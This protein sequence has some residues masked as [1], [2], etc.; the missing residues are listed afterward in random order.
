MR[1]L[2]LTVSWR[3]AD[4]ASAQRLQARLAP[5]VEVRLESSDH[6]GADGGDRIV[7]A[8]VPLTEPS[9]SA[10]ASRLSWACDLAQENGL[11]LI[12]TGVG[13]RAA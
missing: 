12:A 6:L 1:A 2:D 11:E 3:A 5:Q 8:R 13:A 7:S 10:I 4:I 9:A